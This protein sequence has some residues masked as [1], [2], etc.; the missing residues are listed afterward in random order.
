MGFSLPEGMTGDQPDVFEPE[1]VLAT[2]GIQSKGETILQALIQ[3]KG[4]VAEEATWED[5]LTIKSQCPNFCLEDKAN[6][7]GG[8]IVRPNDNELVQSE[9]VVN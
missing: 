2:R 6:V 7:L 4:K 3:W 1:K 5:A 9:P 8:S